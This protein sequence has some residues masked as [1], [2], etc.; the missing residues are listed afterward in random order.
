MEI[1]NVNTGVCHRRLQT[2]EPPYFVN[3]HENGENNY[4][5]FQLRFASEDFKNK[6]V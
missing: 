6:L 2:G 3:W 5:F 4:K 1:T